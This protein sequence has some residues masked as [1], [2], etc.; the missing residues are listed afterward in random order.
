M[1]TIMNH[2]GWTSHETFPF[3]SRGPA[4]MSAPPRILWSPPANVRQTTEVGR[5]LGWLERERGLRFR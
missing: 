2:H 3:G 1:R 5:Y 4:R